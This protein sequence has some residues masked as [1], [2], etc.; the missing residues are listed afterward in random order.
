MS[1]SFT[2]GIVWGPQEYMVD[3]ADQ[4]DSKYPKLSKPEFLELENPTISVAGMVDQACDK[5]CLG[6]LRIVS[7]HSISLSSPPRREHF[8]RHVTKITTMRLRLET[9]SFAR[10]ISSRKKSIAQVVQGVDF[11]GTYPT[12]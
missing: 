10:S 12:I 5:L 4:I 8:L 7:C 11:R 9:F 1:A 3:T 6:G 2:V